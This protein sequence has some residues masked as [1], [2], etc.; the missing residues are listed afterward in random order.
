[1]PVQ[2][3]TPKRAAPEDEDAMDATEPA[4]QARTYFCD[5]KNDEKCA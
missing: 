4:A 2:D 1:V 3:A 5:E